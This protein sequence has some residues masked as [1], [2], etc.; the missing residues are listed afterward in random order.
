MYQR[1]DNLSERQQWILLIE[2]IAQFVEMCSRENASITNAEPADIGAIYAEHLF[3]SARSHGA[4]LLA[5]SGLFVTDE[6]GK[7]VPL[8]PGIRA[9]LDGLLIATTK[10]DP[11]INSLILRAR[12][13]VDLHPTER[14]SSD[15]VEAWLALAT[16][17]RRLPIT[18]LQ[19][20]IDRIAVL[21]LSLAEEIHAL[22]DRCELKCLVD[23]VHDFI[24][25]HDSPVKTLFPHAIARPNSL[26]LKPN[27]QPVARP[28]YHTARELLVLIPDADL[29]T[30]FVIAC[31]SREIQPTSFGDVWSQAVPLQLRGAILA[32]G[33]SLRQNA[34]TLTSGAQIASRVL[35]RHQ[36]GTVFPR[37]RSRGSAER[38]YLTYTW[39]TAMCLAIGLGGRLPGFDELTEAFSQAALSDAALDS[40]EVPHGDDEALQRIEWLANDAALVSNLPFLNQLI[41]GKPGTGATINRTGV[42]SVPLERAHSSSSRELGALRVLFDRPS[43]T[44]KREE[45][46]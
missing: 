12:S 30:L 5:D 40:I 14:R 6:N 23:R 43:S 22:S 27:H 3:A 32:L 15:Q 46:L 38:Q 19:F 16:A 33:L 17:S 20:L 36:I 34:P 9:Y 8:M 4:S 21:D 7:L 25:R 18:D 45:S 37:S 26:H 24:Y 2:S 42:T 1:L 10:D 39:L 28:E 35:L 41:A 13:M 44:L 31:A 29:L 11:L